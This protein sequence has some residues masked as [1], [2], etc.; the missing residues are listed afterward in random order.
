MVSGERI[1]AKI[2]EYAVTATELNTK[3]QIYSAMVVYG[4]LTYDDADGK[5]FIPNKDVFFLWESWV[6]NLNIPEKY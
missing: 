4:L 2:Q 5:V 1:E 3:D 6:K